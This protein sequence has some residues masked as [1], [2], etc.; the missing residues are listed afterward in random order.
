MW[1]TR[2]L[3]TFYFIRQLRTHSIAHK[4]FFFFFCRPTKK[5]SI[6]PSQS[7]DRFPVTVKITHTLINYINTEKNRLTFQ[8]QASKERNCTIWVYYE[9]W[10]Q[11]SRGAMIITSL[12]RTRY[13]F[14]WTVSSKTNKPTMRRDRQKDGEE[15][16]RESWFV[17]WCF[18]HSQP[19][20]IT[21]GL[22][23]NFI[24]SPSYHKS[25]FFSLFI[26][27]GHSTR[28]PASGRVTSFILRAYTGTM[29]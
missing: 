19:Q 27:R 25:C 5:W 16:G 8:R 2:Q 14:Q 23:T 24:L 18:E 1:L 3:R 28:E 22:N 29:C 6:N 9:T 15:R 10:I 20:R 11:L 4:D 21:S 12:T 26:F 17:S 13:R 7:S